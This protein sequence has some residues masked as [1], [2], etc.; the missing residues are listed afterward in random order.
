MNNKYYTAREIV[1]TSANRATLQPFESSIGGS[2]VCGIAIPTSS[3]ATSKTV[4]G[5]GIIPQATQDSGYITLKARQNG[6]E[7]MQQFPVDVIRRQTAQHGFFALNIAEGIDWTQS[8]IQFA[9]S[10]ELSGNGLM[11]AIIH[12]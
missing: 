2:K 1:Q 3:E 6:N 4:N 12:E 5:K 7:V 11:I 8:E 10:T 9:L